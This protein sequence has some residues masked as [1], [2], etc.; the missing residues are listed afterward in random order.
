MN[1]CFGVERIG[2]QFQVARASNRAV[3]IAYITLGYPTLERSLAL[4]EAAIEGGADILELGIPFSDPL[5]DGPVIQRATHVALQHGT[6][7]SLCLELAERLRSSYPHIPL[8]FMGYLNPILAFGEDVFCRACVEA[9]VDGLII[10]DLPPEE[11]EGIEALCRKNELALIYLAA[12]N[13]PENR[14]R[15][16]CEHSQGYVYLVSV[17]GTTGAREG[18]SDEL[19]AFVARV[20][21]ITDTPVAVGFGISTPENAAEV[22]AMAD[23]V[24]VGSAVVQR[25]ESERAE[26]DVKTFVRKLRAAMNR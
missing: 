22:A 17:T 14:L 5:A 4:A 12:P 10:P 25:C 15:I 24:I 9:G 26:T 3:L 19:P 7:V 23:G 13:T 16:I 1:E 6:T 20:R 2:R 21:A 18:V 8:V 11:G